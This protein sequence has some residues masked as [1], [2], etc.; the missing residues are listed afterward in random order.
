MIILRGWVTRTFRK[1]DNVCMG[2]Q[3]DQYVLADLIEEFDKYMDKLDNVQSQIEMEMDIEQLE[4]G[5][6]S[7]GNFWDK[8]RIRRI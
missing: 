5:I 8:V 1:L 7:A 3:V 6:D 2:K 4:Q